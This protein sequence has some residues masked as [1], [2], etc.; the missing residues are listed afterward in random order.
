MAELAEDAIAIDCGPF[1]LLGKAV[2]LVKCTRCGEYSKL[3]GDQQLPPKEESAESANISQENLRCHGRSDSHPKRAWH[4]RI[5]PAEAFECGSPG[6]S[7]I[8]SDD[9][10]KFS[11]GRASD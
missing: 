7:S 8:I 6:Y 2:G 4:A 9:C 3:N 1:D 10:R 5:R 11:A